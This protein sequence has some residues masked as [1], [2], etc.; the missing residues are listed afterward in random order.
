[1]P[2]WT[3]KDNAWKSPSKGWV[4]SSNA[5]KEIKEG[6]VFSSGAWKKIFPNT[7]PGPSSVEYLVV[8]GGG[9]STKN[10]G[11]DAYGA[12]G[13]AGAGGYVSGT[14]A[15]TPGVAYPVVVGAGGAA[16][17]AMQN[18]PSGLEYLGGRIGEQSSFAG[19]V[20]RGGAPGIFYAKGAIDA[21]LLTP[22]GGYGSGSGSSSY[23]WPSGSNRYP[24]PATDQGRAGANWTTDPYGS[25]YRHSGGGGGAGGDG[26]GGNSSGSPSIGGV[27]K[28][29][30]DGQWY[31][32]GGSGMCAR[33]NSDVP[34]NSQGG[35]GAAGPNGSAGQPNTGGGGGSSMTNNNGPHAGGSGIVC[36]RYP[37]TFP[38]AKSV[39]GAS[40]SQSG[41]YHW[42][43]F[44]GTGSITF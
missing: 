4:Y 8:G 32:A 27:G 42:Y 13:G 30:L 2:L 24:F 44:T 9:S 5:W 7:P 43:R 33:F 34:G 26:I 35:G 3:R 21:S 40:H 15:V 25:T 20:G 36:I 17:Y 22:L 6:W 10:D 39:S 41:G 1:M 28:Q 16:I 38:V 19:I 37:D 18:F 14:V 29:W 23:Q 12:P 11:S 31:A